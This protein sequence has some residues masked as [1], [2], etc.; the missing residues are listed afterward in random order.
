M[1]K[2]SLVFLVLPSGHRILFGVFWDVC[3][4]VCAV[5]LSTCVSIPK[6]K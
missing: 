4:C 1:H 5:S 2:A 6:T 3:V